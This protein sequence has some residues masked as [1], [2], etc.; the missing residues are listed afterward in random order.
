MILQPSHRAAFGLGVAALF[1]FPV[2]LDAAD[3]AVTGIRAEHRHGQ[4][5]VT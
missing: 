2:P 5:F 4:T 3:L 1:V